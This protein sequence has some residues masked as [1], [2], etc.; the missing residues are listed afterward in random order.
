M[1]SLREVVADAKEKGIAIA[2]FNVS[3]STQLHGV[4][5]VA[6]ELKLPV[7]IGVSEGEAKFIGRRFL[8]AM[9]KE[10]QRQGKPVYLNADHTHDLVGIQESIDAGFDAVIIDGAKLP[11]EENIKIT[12]EAVALARNSGRDILVEAEL[13]FIG[14]GSKMI[15]VAPTGLEKTNP[16]VAARFVRETGIDLFAPAVGNIHGVLAGGINPHIDIPLLQSI[17]SACGVSLVLHGGSGIPDDDFTQAVQSGIDIIH[18]NTE[19]R[20]AYRKGIEAALLADPKEVT[21]AK[22]LGKG[23]EELKAVVKARMKLF[24]RM[25]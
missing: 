11:L 3:D 13:G 19:I 23:K 17:I 7:I 25:S 9:V 21:P 12:R 15:D 1:K 18:I 24:A 16:E 4:V 6:D 10:Y 5:E 2:H 22:Y 14:E 8:A 20:M